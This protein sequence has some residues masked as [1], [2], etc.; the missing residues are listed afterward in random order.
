MFLSFELIVV[1]IIIVNIVIVNIVINAV[2]HKYPDRNLWNNKEIHKSGF[3]LYNIVKGI[4]VFFC[5]EDKGY[6]GTCTLS[7]HS[8]IF[9]RGGLKRNK[10]SLKAVERGGVGGQRQCLFSRPSY[11][12]SEMDVFL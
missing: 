5:K 1:N 7:V 8:Y 12:S 2:N 10:T 3:I 11:V 9:M 6:P 4:S